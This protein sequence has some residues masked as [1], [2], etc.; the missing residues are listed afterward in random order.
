[1]KKKYM[2][3]I[4]LVIVIVLIIIWAMSYITDNSPSVIWKKYDKKISQTLDNKYKSIKAEYSF[5]INNCYEM[6][7][8]SY[9]GNVFKKEEIITSKETILEVTNLLKTLPKEWQMYISFIPKTQEDI[10]FYCENEKIYM[11]TYHNNSLKTPWTTFYWEQ[12]EAEKKIHEI[13]LEQLK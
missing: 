1:M 8:V 10:Y 6:R 2:I 11:I 7:I 4:M 12:M 9:E 3:I 5:D 13:I